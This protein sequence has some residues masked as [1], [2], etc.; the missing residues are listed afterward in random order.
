M[1]EQKTDTNFGIVINSGSNGVREK[2]SKTPIKEKMQLVQDEKK[3]PILMERLVLLDR[4][5]GE[6]IDMET[7]EES[8]LLTKEMKA[9]LARRGIRYEPGTMGK[10]GQ[11][12][13]YDVF[14]EDQ[15]I[16][17]GLKDLTEVF[18]YISVKFF[19]MKEKSAVSRF[20][21]LK[22]SVQQG[23]NPKK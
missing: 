19:K 17:S 20:K 15:K 7:M 12:F 5:L 11:D 8:N 4:M 21:K 14:Y 16:Q 1:A 13:S 22:R 3:F 2:A 10:Y 9:L 18:A 6:S 23:L